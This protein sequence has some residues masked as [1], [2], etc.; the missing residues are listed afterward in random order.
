[1]RA[2]SGQRAT[3]TPLNPARGSRARAGAAEELPPCAPP[4]APASPPPARAASGA[5]ERDDPGPPQQP[6]GAREQA[7]PPCP[8]SSAPS[9]AQAGGSPASEMH[10]P[11]RWPGPAS[12]RPLSPRAPHQSEAPNRPG[13][14]GRGP[15]AAGSPSGPT[16]LGARLLP[17]SL[18]RSGLFSRISAGRQRPPRPRGQAQCS[19]CTWC[20]PTSRP[21][22]TRS[23]VILFP[24]LAGPR[25]ARF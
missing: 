2:G 7:H 3:E 21:G 11:R 9:L 5:R 6:P 22:W 17:A 8:R 18:G 1:M 13:A 25:R 23:P 4:R 14:A 15:G 12:G 10:S 24:C 20:S 19:L 16:P